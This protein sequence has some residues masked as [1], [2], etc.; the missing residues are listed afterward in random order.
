M[1]IR[2]ITPHPDQEGAVAIWADRADGVE[3]RFAGR[4][5]GADLADLSSRLGGGLPDRLAWAKQVHSDR[6]V[7][8]RPGCCGPGDALVTEEA[9]LALAVVTADCVPVL[10]AGPGQVAAVHAGWRGIAARV[11]EAAIQAM[12][13]PAERMVAWIGPAIGACCY[14][15]GQEVALGVIAASGP[16]V[17]RPGPRGRPYLDLV[18]AVAAQLARAGVA[19]IRRL[20]ICTR[21][22]GDLLASYRRDG[23]GAGRNVALVWRRG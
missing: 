5:L 20:S 21:C 18:A 12:A 11:T 22:E 17:A 8:G 10:L 13:V 3:V 19:E 15:V 23:K 2:D 14:E 7:T 9:A 1:L 4:G 6:V 16:D